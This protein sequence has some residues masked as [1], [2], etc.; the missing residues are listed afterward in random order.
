M[1]A[2]RLLVPLIKTIDSK[3]LPPL[4]LSTRALC[5]GILLTKN[6]SMHIEM[7]QCLLRLIEECPPIT[8]KVFKRVCSL[9]KS[10]S[11]I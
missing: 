3:D 11:R 6:T 8:K 9:K 7:A 5:D 4:V 2:T 10:I 1:E